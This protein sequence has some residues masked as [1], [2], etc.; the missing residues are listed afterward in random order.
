MGDFAMRS[1][2]RATFAFVGGAALLLAACANIQPFWAP[3]PE[4]PPP[5]PP[6]AEMPPPPP[7]P[8]P[9]GPPRSQ[10]PPPAPPPAAMDQRAK[11]KQLAEACRPDLAR[12]CASVP[13]GE[14]RKVQC[15]M[16][17]RPELT[18]QCKAALARGT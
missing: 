11:G 9:P 4:P 2:R 12:F 10:Y 17:H 13:Q 6:M 8:P 5:P 18:K 1:N 15:L 14:G 7:A 16:A 3:A